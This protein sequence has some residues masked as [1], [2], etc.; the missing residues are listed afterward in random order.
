M[1]LRLAIEFGGEDAVWETGSETLDLIFDF[2]ER[3][4]GG[5]VENVAIGRGGVDSLESAQTFF[6]IIPCLG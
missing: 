1:W 4:G 6:R 2:V 5:A 3:L